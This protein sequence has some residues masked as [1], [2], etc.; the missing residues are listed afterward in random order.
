M[1]DERVTFLPMQR[2]TEARPWGPAWTA[3]GRDDSRWQTDTWLSVAA[4]A[5]TEKAVGLNVAYVLHN[6]HRIEWNVMIDGRPNETLDPPSDHMEGGEYVDG[7]PVYWEV[8]QLV[9]GE[10]WNVF[11]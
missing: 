7:P 3:Q 4:I 5:I 9:D 2:V 1:T 8:R 11:A 6:G 10:W